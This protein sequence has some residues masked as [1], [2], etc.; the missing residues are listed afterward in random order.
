MKEILN[1]NGCCKTL[2]VLSL[3]LV[4]GGSPAYAD[5]GSLHLD[6]SNFD[7]GT[8]DPNTTYPEGLPI[9]VGC[10]FDLNGDGVVNDRDVNLALDMFRGIEP[11]N[12]PDGHDC[13]FALASSV[14]AYYGTTECPLQLHD[15]M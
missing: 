4:V 3:F 13:S 10:E 8:A 5:S 15:Q 7:P 11:C 6:S 9:I 12:A 2:G 14:L 1:L